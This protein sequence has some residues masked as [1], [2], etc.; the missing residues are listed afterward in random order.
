MGI[1][2]LD[3]LNKSFFP[4]TYD[5]IKEVLDEIKKVSSKITINNITEKS[6]MIILFSLQSYMNILPLNLLTIYLCYLKNSQIFH[7][8]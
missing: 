8:F 3:K 7:L 4:V 6:F 1:S 2:K 5:E